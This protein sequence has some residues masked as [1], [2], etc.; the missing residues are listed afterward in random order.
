MIYHLKFK[1]G[2]REI[3]FFFLLGKNL[4]AALAEDHK[5]KKG[6]KMGGKIV[7]ALQMAASLA[8]RARLVELLQGL[9]R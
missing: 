7:Q 2:I 6:E 1:T 8:C 9:P 3:R 5:D 4:P